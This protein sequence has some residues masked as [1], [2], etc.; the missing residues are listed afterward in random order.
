MLSFEGNEIRED[1]VKVISIRLKRGEL[2][3][4]IR[5]LKKELKRK[6]VVISSA[7]AL[8]LKD[9]AELSEIFKEKNINY[10]FEPAL[11]LGIQIQADDMEYN[12]NLK[13]KLEEI[14]KFATN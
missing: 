3:E 13:N 6:T 7:F 8:S 4:Y 12:L 14:A 1:L 11:I 2:K 5:L 9:K 10:K